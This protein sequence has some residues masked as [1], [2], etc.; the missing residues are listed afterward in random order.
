MTTRFN[1]VPTVTLHSAADPETGK[2]GFTYR[3]DGVP[4]ARTLWYARPC[5]AK[6]AAADFVRNTNKMA[7]AIDAARCSRFSTV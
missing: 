1:H 4:Q 5:H 6:V 3:L 7:N 2:A